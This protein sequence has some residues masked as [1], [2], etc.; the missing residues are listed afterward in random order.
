[1]NKLNITRKEFEEKF[2]L[3]S[4]SDGDWFHGQEIDAFDVWYFFESKLKEARED[5]RQLVVMMKKL[6]KIVKLTTVGVYTEIG[7]FHLNQFLTRTYHLLN[8]LQSKEKTK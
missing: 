3:H 2:N 5:E 4:D 8:I 7:I 6:I 1:M